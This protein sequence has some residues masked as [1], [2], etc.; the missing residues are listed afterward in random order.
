MEEA[1]ADEMSAAEAALF[2]KAVADARS[3]GGGSDPASA[4]PAAPSAPGGFTMPS[5]PNPIA[6]AFGAGG[7]AQLDADTAARDLAASEAQAKKAKAWDAT[8]EAGGNPLA[9]V[10]P[11]KMMSSFMGELGQN[12]KNIAEASQE[13]LKEADEKRLEERKAQ[14]ELEK[15]AP[16]KK[17]RIPF[18]SKDVK[19]LYADL[20]AAI[21]RSDYTAAAKIKAEIDSIK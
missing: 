18:F 6:N 10:D 16:K 5:I 19:T 21:E 15:N 14:L 7:G 11:M 17:G 12:A 3:R 9:G 1:T 20:D 8:L 13:A 2:E 4:A